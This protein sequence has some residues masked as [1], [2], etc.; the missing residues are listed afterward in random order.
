MG[1]ASPETMAPSVAPMI[2]TTGTMPSLTDLFGQ[3]LKHHQHLAAL[4]WCAG[5][6][7]RQPPQPGRGGEFAA[8]ERALQKALLLK[9]DEQ[10]VQG[11][12]GQVDAGIKVGG[13]D[14]FT[15]GGDLFQQ[16]QK[17]QIGGDASLCRARV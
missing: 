1:V 14:R 13:G 15:D 5:H 4:L 10:A 17:A 9:G 8:I 3:R 6:L 12:F 7:H 16:H 2:P 11:R